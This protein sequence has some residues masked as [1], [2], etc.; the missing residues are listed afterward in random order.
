MK[1]VKMTKDERTVLL[2]INGVY[3]LLLL[4]QPPNCHIM[5]SSI[6]LIPAV[7]ALVASISAQKV[8][9]TLPSMELSL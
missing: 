6:K 2:D 9:Q 7:L 5:V 3:D 4:T 8:L 1:R